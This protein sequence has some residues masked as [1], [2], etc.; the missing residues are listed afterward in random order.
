M[1]FFSMRSNLFAVAL[2]A[3]A[4]LSLLAASPATSQARELPDFVSLY[5]NNSPSVVSISVSATVNRN[6]PRAEKKDDGDGDN[7]Q[8]DREEMEEFFRRYFGGGRPG[9]PREFRRQGGGSGFVISSDGVIVTNAHVVENADEV[10][11]KFSDRREL[12][13]KILGSDNRTDVAVIKVEATGLTA[14]KIGNPDALKIGEWVAAIGQPLGFENTLTSGIISAKARASRGGSTTGE[15]VPYIQHDAAVNPGNSGGPLFNVKGEVVAIN[16]MIATVSGGFQGISFAIPIDLAMDVVKQ[17]QN[18]GTVK[19]GLLGVNIGAVSRDLAEALGLSRAYGAVV[20]GV[21]KGSAAEKAGIKEEDVI[22]QFNGRTVEVSSDLPRYVTAVRPG[23]PSKVQ[24]WRDKK[25]VELTV[26]LDEAKEA[27]ASA[28]PAVR[29]TPKAA[30]TKPETVKDDRLGI[31][32]RALTEKERTAADV[33]TGGA[34]VASLDE[35]SAVRSLAEG[36]IILSVT[37]GGTRANVDSPSQL[38]ALIKEAT[39]GSSVAFR[40]KRAT[41]RA[42]TEF[43]Q[44]FAPEKM[45]E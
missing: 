24:V 30:P 39:K 43:Q 13:A 44:F 14:V 22:T 26:T 9:A 8:P 20:S 31:S 23:T 36:D 40:V 4:S 6:R 41:D 12:K 29:A 15:L 25:L 35:K 18:G 28:S 42:G 27:V 38:V 11:V 3:A 45:P 16:S 1:K 19:R 33:K 34:V 17:L 10:I 7:A 21:S 2:G 5:E 37:R 32:Y